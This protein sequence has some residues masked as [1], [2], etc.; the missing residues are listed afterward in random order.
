M[1]FS[2]RPET[3]STVH[4]LRHPERIAFVAWFICCVALIARNGW[5]LIHVNFFDPDDALRL[6]QVRDWLAG[7]SWFD[8]TQYRASP[9]QGAPMHWSRI[10]DL[11]IGVLILLA[12]PL[13]GPAAAEILATVTVPLLL[14]GG[15]TAATYVIGE[16][17]V[18]GRYA[19]L[20]GTIMLLTTPSILVQFP[21]FRIDHHG[22]QILLGA[23]ATCGLFD[24]QPRRGGLVLGTA[25]AAWL[26]ISSEA[27][28]YI[29]LFLGGTGAL[30]LLSARDTDRLVNAAAAI[31]VAGL[32]LS[33]ATRGLVPLQ[34]VQC[35][36][37][38]VPYLYPL[39]A[40]AIAT[41][42]ASAIM[43]NGDWLRRLIVGA[44]GAGA[45]ITTLA[46]VGGPCLS[47]DPF[48]TLGPL[49]Y[50]VWYMAIM[51][52]RP[53]W[54][55]DLSLMG[56]ILLP[57]LGGMAATVAAA[58]ASRHDSE[59]FRRWLLLAWLLAGATLI[60]A[61][62]MRA[63]SIAHWLAIPGMTW[64]VMT[65][66]AKVQTL[67]SAVQRVPG[68]ASLA[69]L[70]PFGLSAL[71]VALAIPFESPAE[72]ANQKALKCKPS[73]MM[74]QVRA[75]PPS[76]LFA[77]LDIG[78]TILVRTD[79]RIVA[80]GHHRN[81]AG[82]TTVIRGFT[83]RPEAARAIIAGVNDGKGAD[84]LL[85][86]SD[87]NEYRA[88][89]KIAPHGLAAQLSRGRVPAWL[90]PLPGKGPLRIYRVNRAGS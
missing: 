52:G 23:V 47:G 71:W 29:P 84:Y 64:L 69:L 87:L 54:E 73:M 90:T 62:V 27:L 14:L 31:G 82:I 57:P 76:L 78:P 28:P 61:M 55:Q 65:L 42:A 88:Y 72:V 77:P 68:S 25:L 37:L 6:Q 3:G 16:R 35:D 10:V 12:R 89:I 41:P 36:A 22:W 74:G 46:L 4:W 75:L 24:P 66:F 38:T 83:E 9:P 45:A 32:I 43:G 40:L 86:C 70:T 51:E 39:I 17:V 13:I 58:Y 81:A 8:V 56:I 67:P 50:R 1:V 5:P 26:A 80:T 53:V 2:P 33:I 30:H 7:Q 60:A 18:G 48:Q 21:P 44:V 11:P 63:L 49:A 79:Q 59:Q 34:A 20:L 15:L 85:T 19:A